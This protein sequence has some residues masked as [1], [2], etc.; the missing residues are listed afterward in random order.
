MVNP[1]RWTAPEP[2]LNYW[3][4]T[5][6]YDA[7]KRANFEALLHSHFAKHPAFVNEKWVMLV[8]MSDGRD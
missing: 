7:E 3:Q 6:F 2:V 8:E 5:T 4:N 1:V